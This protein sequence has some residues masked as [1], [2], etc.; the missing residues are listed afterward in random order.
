M[1]KLGNVEAICMTGNLPA[2]VK[3]DPNLA[4]N[5]EFLEECLV[6]V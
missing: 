1:V 6:K 2:P 3:V 4:R 5:N